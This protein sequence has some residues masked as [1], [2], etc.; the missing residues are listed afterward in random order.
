MKN[1][2]LISLF[3]LL[4]SYSLSIAQDKQIIKQTDFEVYSIYGI[5]TAYSEFSPVLYK[6]NFVFVSDREYDIKTLGEGNWKKTIH[7]NIFNAKFEDIFSDSIVLE[8][9][10]LFDNNLVKDD[11]VGPITFNKEGNEAVVTIVTHKESKPFGKA[12]AYPQLYLVKKDNNKWKNLEL[13]PFNEAKQSFAQPTW[14]VD[15]KRLYFALNKNP[16]SNESDLYFVEKKDSTWGK[17]T[18][19]KNINSM[20]N[21]MFPYLID[22]KIYFASDRDGGFGGLDLYVSEWK[23]N[24]WSEPKNLGSTINTE[25]DE[26]SMVF[27]VNK[28]SGY[29]CSNRSYGK[30]K[31][32]IFAFELI[33]KTIIKDLALKG[34]LTYRKLKNKSTEGLTI[35]MYDEDGVLIE[36]AKVRSD[37][38]FIFKKIP[39]DQKYTLKVI[40]Q[41][42]EMILTLLNQKDDIILISDKKGDF[43]YRKLSNSKVGT[44]SLIAQEDIDLLNKNGDLAGQFIFKKL[45]NKKTEGM[46]I[47]LVDEDG[48]IVMKTKTDKY[49][50]FIFKK[51]PTG[52]NYTLKSDSDEDFDILVFNKKD[53]LLARLTKDDKGN[54]IYRKLNS[55][56]NNINALNQEEESLIFLEKRATLMGQFVY[57]KLKRTLVYWQLKF[58]MISSY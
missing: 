8:K 18:K 28:T 9:I 30:G 19:V 1:R 47:Y 24:E 20:Q 26:F 50:N 55:S 13:L 39:H 52:S 6:D 23:N 38:T 58:M 40:D 22:N 15:G 11:H 21:D 32:D 7:V 54:F 17:P 34:A 16:G 45:D 51:I 31:D 46:D 14:S 5:N 36:T 4:F 33:E 48:N 2:Q 43:I 56:S 29:F 57:K 3:I 41:G 27:N 49:G 35:G 44:F 37:G 42:N 12:L 53:Q 25:A 10:N